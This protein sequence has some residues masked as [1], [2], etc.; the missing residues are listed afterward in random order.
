MKNKI[1]NLDKAAERIKKSV[2]NNER[3]IIYGD[4]DCDGITSVVILEETIKNLGGK[5][6]AVFFPNR[7]ND[8]YGINARALEVLKSKAPA[9]FITLDLGIG[10]IREIEALNSYGFEVIVIDHHQ[11]LEKIPDAKI[12]VDPQQAGDESE[13]QY[14]CNAGLTFKPAEE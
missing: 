12:V 11:V 4:S 1:K 9:L 7:E 10:N 14:L 13:Y 8:G 5:V 2:K 3:I 6:E